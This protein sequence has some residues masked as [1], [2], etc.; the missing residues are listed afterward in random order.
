MFGL[1]SKNCPSKHLSNMG[2]ELVIPISKSYDGTKLIKQP[3]IKNIDIDKFCAFCLLE[4]HIK[5]TVSKRTD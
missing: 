5:G 2:S 3:L 4:S 1:H